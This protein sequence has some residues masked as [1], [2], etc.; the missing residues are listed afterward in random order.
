MLIIGIDILP[1]HF[2]FPYLQVDDW[3]IPA[4][5]DDW[6]A[7]PKG[8]LSISPQPKDDW[9]LS[10][11]KE[12]LNKD[13]WSLTSPKEIL[14]SP[15]DEWSLPPIVPQGT[16]SQGSAEKVIYSREID[17]PSVDVPSHSLVGRCR[18][19]FF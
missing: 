18:K 4:P 16:T 17:S 9:C 13:D 1:I 8:E 19:D 10:S 6:S 7:P 5:T 15:V 3:S 11:P 12:I 2:T 14:S